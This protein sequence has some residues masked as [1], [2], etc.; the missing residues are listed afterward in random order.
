[1]SIV[2]R[3]NKGSALTYDE[4]D[5]NQSQFFYSSSLVDNGTT[6]RLHYTGSDSLDIVEGAVAVDYGP[7]R[8]QDIPFPQ[9][10]VSTLPQSNVA[11]QANEIQFRDDTND[12]FG[13]DPLFVFNSSS[14]TM[15]LGVTAPTY[16][17]TIAGDTSRSATIALSGG[18]SDD[19][20]SLANRAIIKFFNTGFGSA[21]LIGQLGKL[22][23]L[24]NSS[25]VDDFFIHAGTEAISGTSSALVPS[26]L[27]KL[28]IAL[29]D[30]S[31]SNNLSSRIGATFSR[32][33]SSQANLGV[34]NTT[35]EINLSV[36]GSTGIGVS[37]SS[38]AKEDHSIIKSITDGNDFF[39]K[40]NGFGLRP[41]FPTGA[42]SKGVEIST[43]NTAN[44]GS[45][46]MIINTD[47]EKHEAFSII[48][49]P[50]GDSLTEN[51]LNNTSVLATFQASGKVGIGTNFPTHEGLTIQE[52]LS[53]KGLETGTSV[54]TKTLVAT[55]TGLVK[56]IA[57][58]PVPLG[59]IIMWSGTT[60]PAGWR[61]CEDGV[62]EVNGIQVPNLTDK[63]IVGAGD[64]YSP[65]NT[66]GYKDAAVIDHNH[67]GSTT[68]GGGH[69]HEYKD[70]MFAEEYNN[71]TQ[72]GYIDNVDQIMSGGS[73]K[74]TTTDTNGSGV[75][76][77]SMNRN[78]QNENSHTHGITATG[79]SGTNR[80]LPPYYALAYIIYVGV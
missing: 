54:N 49:K 38:S 36:V 69:L 34:N 40:I 24:G 76:S 71:A 75:W 37:S 22:Q 59:G 78:T 21:A 73:N 33:A 62:G 52:Q 60:A 6:L 32:N 27:R 10:D 64:T 30:V 66:G 48:Q 17:L 63:F 58:A 23:H 25:D 16:R 19:D 45:M 47:T 67:G 39:G 3:T 14:N 7:A 9:F 65:G 74:N 5:R 72:S 4:M 77:Y 41:L 50:F 13:A 2:L 42:V 79:I 43:P 8:Y 35:P 46:L 20:D 80:N 11:G 51:N 1:M 18:S 55:S 61:I 56:Q 12:N 70:T 26:T 53:I 44:G 68:A 28:H 57:A 31:N 15:G 29:G